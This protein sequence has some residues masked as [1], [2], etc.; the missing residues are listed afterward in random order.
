M[1]AAEKGVALDVVPLDVVGGENR[2]E[3]H[4][5]RNPLGTTPVL[6]L[7]SGRCFSEAV[8]ICE[9]LEELCPQPALIGT[10]P[11][12]RAETRMWTRR[13]D[14]GIA[15]PMVNGYRAADRREMFETRMKLVSPAA[16]AELKA[17]ARDRVIWLDGRMSELTYVCGERFSMADIMLF[18]FLRFGEDFG[19]PIPTEAATLRRWYERVKERPSSAA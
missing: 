18:A 15:E 4:L 7:P 10:T 17:L 11:E 6:E 14:L 5:T 12:E 9:Y 16:A 8:A 1:F 13:I 19:Q 2:R 3:P